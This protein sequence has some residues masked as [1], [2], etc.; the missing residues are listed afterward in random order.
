MKKLFRLYGLIILILFSCDSENALDCVKKSGNT[1]TNEV[2]V[3]PFDK[4]R[5]YDNINL[6]LKNGPEI[7]ISIEGGKNLLPKINFEVLDNILI[8]SNDNSCNWVRSYRDLNVFVTHPGIS[9]I[10]LQGYGTLSS[11]GTLEVQDLRIIVEGSTSDIDL[12]LAGDQ[13]TITSNYISNIYLSGNLNQLNVQFYNNDG[14]LF[15]SELNAVSI[16][17]E[18]WGTNSMKVSPS[19]LLSGEIRSFG[20]VEL[21][22][23]PKVIEV[24]Y[25]GDGQV[26]KVD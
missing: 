7:G 19:Q 16:N 17:F 15:A 22:S 20:N 6:I 21:F 3:D 23:D 9:D 24:K 10:Y 25:L 2:S 13:L 8:I 11:Y 14:I 12:I 4:I 1:V 5:V 26:I 18:H